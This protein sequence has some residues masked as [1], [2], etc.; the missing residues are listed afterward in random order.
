MS[1][2]IKVQFLGNSSIDV[3]Q[4]CYQILSDKYTILLDYGLYQDQNP[5]ENYKLNHKKIKDIRQRRLDYIFISHANIDHCGALPELYARG[6]RAR[7]IVPS[8]NKELIRLMLLDSAKIMASD[9]E[10]LRKVYKM[11]AVP[12]YTPEDVEI[13]ME[14]MEEFSV[15]VEHVLA[16]DLSFRFYGANHIVNAAQILLVMKNELDIPKR[17]FYTGDI[18]SPHIPK[19]YTLGFEY[20]TEYI[21]LVI[22]ESTYA[23]DK[24]VS[25]I[26]DRDKDKEKIR[27]VIEESCVQA[28]GKVLFPVFALDRLQ[29]VLTVLYE[30]YG[31]DENFK[32][33]IIVD[34]P[35]GISVTKM[36]NDLIPC[37]RE[38]WE[39]VLSWDN[40]YF[41]SSWEDS[42]ACQ[43]DSRPMIVLASSGM[44]TNGRSVVWAKT[45]LPSE[46]N[47]ICFCGYSAAGSLAAKIKE[48]SSKN[49]VIQIEGKKV[50]NRA[51]VTSLF[52]FSSHACRSELMWYYG[53]LRYGHLCLVHGE[54][55]SKLEFGVELRHNLGGIGN[56][57]PV[58]GAF[59][60]Y[61]VMI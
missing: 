2:K 31:A 24:R 40:V 56:S 25:H 33:P 28:H 49:A 44:C 11:N 59:T 14:Y 3:T 29:T 9:A 60:G 34:T 52:S 51:K 32:L 8:G 57:S 12:L 4:S 41:T 27:Q 55:Q 23:G 7:I 42:M 50:A 54:R 46:R 37:N 35:L 61:E 20:P 17:I 13:C 10:K 47:Y 19:L 15:G 58:T 16:E 26:K 1:K 38:L 22:G 48:G 5:V 36:W 53:I 21:D 30:I 43:K 39:K 6:C 45:L 18:G